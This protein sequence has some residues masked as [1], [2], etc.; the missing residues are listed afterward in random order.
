[1]IASGV[2]V[3]SFGMS[4]V[5]GKKR[6]LFCWEGD[7][8]F[9]FVEGGTQRPNL[10]CASHTAQYPLRGQRI[11]VSIAFMWYRASIAEIHSLKKRKGY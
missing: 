5:L 8:C 9:N 1:M 2:L 3:G 11:H 7:Q 6:V 4:V 10:R